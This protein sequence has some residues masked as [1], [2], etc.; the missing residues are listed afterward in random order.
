[1]LIEVSDK[2]SG[3]STGEVFYVSSWGEPNN[4]D[5]ISSLKIKSDTQKYQI[6]QNAKVEF[7]SVAGAKAL[8][9][10]ECEFVSKLSKA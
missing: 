3:V 7:E 2:E 5:I 4:A 1:M 10:C 9:L 8:Y 6:G